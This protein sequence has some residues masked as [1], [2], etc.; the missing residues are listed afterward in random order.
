MLFH[1]LI[2]IIPLE[3]SKLPFY[4]FDFKENSIFALFILLLSITF[5]TLLC[6]PT[7]IYIPHKAYTITIQNLPLTRYKFEIE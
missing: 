1:N 7:Q 6:L 4:S 3:I 2:T 5:P